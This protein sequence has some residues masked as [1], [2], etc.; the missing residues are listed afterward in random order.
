MLQYAVLR[1]DVST[2]SPPGC[3]S[4]VFGKKSN[5]FGAGCGVTV[6]ANELLKNTISALAVK[7][8]KKPVM[9]TK[10]S[11]AMLAKELYD[12]FILNAH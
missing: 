1:I 6:T 7:G 8:T 10:Y 4:H 12:F 3:T 11:V 9:K 2:I 5:A